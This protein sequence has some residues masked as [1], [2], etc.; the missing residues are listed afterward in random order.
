[1][2]NSSNICF[3][4]E[5]LHKNVLCAMK[6]NTK[7]LYI[8]MESLSVVFYLLCNICRI[9]SQ[10]IHEILNGQIHWVFAQSLCE[11]V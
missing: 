10:F 11:R 4:S 8:K 5:F 3:T 7:L 9:C 2:A 6:F 1:M